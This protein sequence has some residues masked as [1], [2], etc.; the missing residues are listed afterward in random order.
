MN[1]SINQKIL[2]L[3]LAVTLGVPLVG[4]I[5]IRKGK[6]VSG[7]YKEITSHSLPATQS[8]GQL[9]FKFRQ[10]RIVV[11]SIP[12]AGNDPATVKK[13]M[14]ATS[15]AVTEFE[16][17]LKSAESL[18]R[19][20]EEKADYDAIIRGWVAFKNFGGEL[21]GLAKKGDP[22]S[23]ARVAVL[24]RD[25]C[26]EKTKDIEAALFKATTIFADSAQ[27]AVDEANATSENAETL[28]FTLSATLSV[29]SLCLAWWISSRLSG[30]LFEMTGKMGA[31]SK[32]LGGVV[33][34]VGDASEKLSGA[35]QQQSK[36]V[37]ETS[38]ALEQISTMV[39]KSADLASEAERATILSSEKAEEGKA[40]VNQMKASMDSIRMTNDQ[41]AQEMSES[42]TQVEQ[43]LKV[44][45]EVRMKTQVI[46]DIVFQ[47]K[48]LSFNA[49]V[50]AARAGEHGRGFSVVAEE[51]GNLARM[52]GVAALEI[53][54]ILEK[55]TREVSQT[56]QDTK[57]RLDRM[58]GTSQKVIQD[59]T[60]VAN[61]CYLAL[62][63]IVESS[64][65][66]SRLV[67]DITSGSKES[68]QGI[69]GITNSLKQIDDASRVTLQSASDCLRS[70]QML[71]KESGELQGIADVLDFTVKGRRDVGKAS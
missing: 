54:A 7:V 44:I 69:Q 71:S 23:L 8:M 70:S 68:A 27:K 36:A 32:I 46:N 4:Y 66:V 62:Q 12:I 35:S 26:P 49:S 58:V 18:F 57:T 25:V 51:V 50:E 10:I 63:N 47:T 59:G 61:N 67:A 11:R 3:A 17:A 13:Y 30:S 29:F 33:E 65:N 31:S 6:E 16:E 24:V 38:V 1:L 20:P 28:I 22:E 15:L 48:L 9:L 19:T 14:E 5:S 60:V 37:E 39:T 43:I 55:S 53:N 2:G 40:I 45:E 41:S 64:G 42:N 21:L 52:S 34:Q 56:V